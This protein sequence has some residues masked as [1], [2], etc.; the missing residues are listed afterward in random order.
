MKR[1]RWWWLGG[2]LAAAGC[3]GS[4]EDGEAEAS[5]TAARV[6]GRVASLH[7]DEG[8]VLIE[9][10]GGGALGQGLLLSTLGT[11]GASATLVV[12]GERMG[13]YA[14]ADFKSGDVAVGDAAY[15]RPLRER[16]VPGGEDEGETGTSEAEFPTDWPVENPRSEGGGTER[17]RPG[18]PED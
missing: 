10:T 15:G 4:G 17:G 8:F 6:V 5:P 11:N 16:S 3:A 7:L 13:R 12:S 18:A 1:I 14:A 9:T 2:L